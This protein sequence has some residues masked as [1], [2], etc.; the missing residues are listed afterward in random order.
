MLA[1]LENG[2][3]STLHWKPA[4]GL[5][6]GVAVT[7]NVMDVEGVLLAFC[8]AAPLP[9]VAETIVVCVGGRIPITETVF[10]HVLATYM[11]LLVGLNA[12][13]TG[14]FPTLIILE[15]LSI[16]ETVFELKLVTYMSLLLGLNAIPSGSFPT[17]IV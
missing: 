16:A 13:P 8:T 1:Q 3:L 9:S 4:I 17:F 12:A 6:P 15:E 7:W 2:L 11:S 5:V 14:A 10:E